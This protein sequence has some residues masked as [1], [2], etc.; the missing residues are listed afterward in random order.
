SRRKIFV[1]RPESA[2]DELPCAREIVARIARQAFRRPVTDADLELPLRFYERGRQNGDFETGIERA[3]TIVLAS[4]E[5]LYRVEPHPSDLQ[6]GA[7]YEIGDFELA[8]RLSF[9]LWSRLP[10]EELLALAEAGRLRD[11]AV[12]KAQVRRMLA[13]PRSQAPVTHVAVQW[14]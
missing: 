12:L 11:P 14:L 2:P 1:C 6:A 4:P 13:D 10:D 8:S 9:F 3:L 7:V 5:F